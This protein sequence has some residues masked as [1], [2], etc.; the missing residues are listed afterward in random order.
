Q[1]MDERG[2]RAARS[3]SRLVRAPPSSCHHRPPHVTLSA[4]RPRRT[5]ERG[6]MAIRTL[7][8]DFGNVLATFSHRRAAEQIAAFSPFPVPEVQAVLCDPGL[9][10]DFESGRL[11]TADLLAHLRR[12]LD[13]DAGDEEIGLAVAD[14]FTR[15]EA[16]CALVPA[17]VGRYRL[18]MLS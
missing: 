8:F 17:L 1:S 18:A 11:S 2:Q 10:D 16:V 3:R 14:M 7:V 13:L 12:R 4:G 15:N 9:E 6:P 5:E